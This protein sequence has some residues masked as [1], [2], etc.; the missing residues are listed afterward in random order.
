MS[1]LLGVAALFTAHA[2]RLLALTLRYPMRLFSSRCTIEEPCATGA[3]AGARAT[4]SSSGVVT[5][6]SLV[7]PLYTRGSE[8]GK[9]HYGLQLFCRNVQQL[10]LAMG[11]PALQPPKQI[12]PGLQALIERIHSHGPLPTSRL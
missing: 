4:P 5:A 7:F 9:L 3:G 12:L 8:P 2:A 6:R 11:E 1:A 10:L